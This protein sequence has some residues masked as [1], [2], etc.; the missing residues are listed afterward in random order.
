MSR[1][2]LELGVLALQL[3]Q[4]PGVRDVR[5]AEFG[6]PLVEGRIAEAVLAAQLLERQPSLGLFDEADG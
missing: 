1:W 5:A 6:P 3:M 4:P 2:A